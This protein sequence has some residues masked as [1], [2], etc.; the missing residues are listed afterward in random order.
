MSYADQR[1]SCSDLSARGKRRLSAFGGP[2][3][4]A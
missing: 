1:W 4:V 3:D 2:N